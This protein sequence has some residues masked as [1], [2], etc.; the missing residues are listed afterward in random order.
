MLYNSEVPITDNL[1]Q[2]LTQSLVGQFELIP[3]ETFFDEVFANSKASKGHIS[4]IYLRTYAIPRSITVSDL[5]DPTS[6]VFRNQSVLF[7]SIWNFTF[8]TSS[9]FSTSLTTPPLAEDGE[10]KTTVFVSE[11]MDLLHRIILQEVVAFY[12]KKLL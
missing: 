7:E 12:A 1:L 3:D 5:L 9:K 11:E 10:S 6:Q 8:Y 2:I 4:I